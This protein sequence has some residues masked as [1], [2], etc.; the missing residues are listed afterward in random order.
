MFSKPPALVWTEFP[1]MWVLMK[2]EMP[3]SI[4]E[5]EVWVMSPPAMTPGTWGVG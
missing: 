3:L 5:A 4:T 1:T 2:G